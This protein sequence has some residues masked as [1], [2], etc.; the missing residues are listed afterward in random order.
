M[1]DGASPKGDPVLCARDDTLR[2]YL[3]RLFLPVDDG[4]LAADIS[5]ENRQ[6][7]KAHLGPVTIHP[8]SKAVLL[9]EIRTR[10]GAALLD[11]AV[12]GLAR[13]F[14]QLSAQTVITR[15]QKAVLGALAAAGLAA[16]ALAPL[17]AFHVMIAVLSLAF[18]GAGL[19]RVTLAILATWRHPAPLYPPAAKAALPTYTIL[20]PMYR[21]AAVLPG[22]MRG[23]SALDYPRHLLDIKLVLEEDDLETVAAARALEGAA[24]F[25][26]FE[27]VEVPPGGPRTKPN[28]DGDLLSAIPRGSKSFDFARLFS[29]RPWPSWPPPLE[30]FGGVFLGM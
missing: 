15:P 25:A 30:P 28:S 5:P 16:L 24:G 17:P 26:P 13:R 4:V 14:P 29:G 10:H 20:V 21:E 19:F 23:L 3:T 12:F 2:L 9:A 27:I 6:W 7:L 11:A 1:E 22:L 8:V 18:A